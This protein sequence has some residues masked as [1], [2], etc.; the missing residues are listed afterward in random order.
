MNGQN[1]HFGIR[2]RLLTGFA[3]VV[4][5]FVISSMVTLYFVRSI[6]SDT[7]E[8]LSYYLPSQHNLIDMQSEVNELQLYVTTLVLL[9]DN[10]M[11]DK[12]DK[13]V[14][15]I[16]NLMTETDSTIKI[17]KSNDISKRWRN[18]S[19]NIDEYQDKLQLAINAVDS[20]SPDKAVDI[21]KNDIL[22]LSHKLN[23]SFNAEVDAQENQH[24]IVDVMN[25]VLNDDVIDIGRQVDTLFKYSII[26]VC[27]S[28]LLSYI[29]AT[30]TSR[31]I[32][33]PISYAID[34]AKN[35]AAGRRDI[36]IKIKKF[37]ETGVLLDALKSMLKSIKDS[38]IK[39]NEIANENKKL[40]ESVVKAANL[41]SKHT[42]RVAS[43][44]LVD[45]IDIG[46]GLI[47]QES[48]VTLGND[49]NHMTDNLA[50]ITNDIMQACTSMVSTLEEVRHA[51]DAQ[52]S[53]ASEQASSIN[54]IT[55]SIT[56]IEKSATQTM[57]KAKELG[58]VAEKTRQ[59]GQRGLESIESSVMGMKAVRDRV[60]LIA[61][62][63]L[64]LSRQTQ[65]VGEITSVVNNLAQQSKMLALN[66]SIEAAKAGD[67]GKGFAVV[68]S[69]VKSL[70]EQSEESTSQ[71][72][73]I[74]EDIRIATEKAVMV[75]EEG[76]KGVDDG[77]QMIEHTGEIIRDL[78]DVIREASIASQQIEAAV[79]QEGAG[80]EQ[81]TAGMNEINTVTASFVES[82]SQTSEAMDNLSKVT[83]KLKSSVDTYKI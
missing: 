41:F 62:T 10:T 21:Y 74:L 9:H 2:A 4:L 56:E 6:Q 31:S 40:Y 53:G 43:G 75:T 42:G 55:A 18:I 58:G 7:H 33:S 35:I 36:D 11:R 49:L 16:R 27:I 81:I 51:V 61:Q 39:I 1:K 32:L 64:D 59:S 44:D 30:L 45:R 83:N 12:I 15:V 23:N 26:F 73:K 80:I 72:Q 77:L 14:K 57:N 37:D 82:V 54:E 24:G 47:N 34:I 25:I 46:S 48:M 68:A 70:A 8:F 66:A 69:E 22:P 17:L 71:V 29:I 65:Q 52:S 67:A 19:S 3:S 76:T 38:E 13:E 20:G 63:I 5:V 50:T 78:N 28:V 79:R 60:Q